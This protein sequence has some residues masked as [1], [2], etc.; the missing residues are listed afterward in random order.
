MPRA[1][2]E[3]IQDALEYARK[4]VQAARA[5]GPDAIR[6]SDLKLH[7]LVRLLELV[8]EALSGVLAPLRDG[9]PQIPWREAMAVRNK[10][11]HAVHEVDFR[12]VRDTITLR[13]PP[14]IVELE[15]ALTGKQ[16]SGGRPS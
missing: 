5:E 9:H 4:A 14:L 8:G 11:I 7:G 16:P 15:R 2:H 13:L 6:A 3:R 10:L 1:D 12:I